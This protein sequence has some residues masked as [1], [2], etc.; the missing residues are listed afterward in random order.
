ML[1][2]VIHKK[3]PGLLQTMYSTFFSKIR[4]LS[5][6]HVLTVLIL[7]GLL[8]GWVLT[9]PEQPKTPD[10]PVLLAKEKPSAQ[11]KAEPK[12]I[13]FAQNKPRVRPDL[14]LREFGQ[15]SPTK[16]FRRAALAELQRTILGV[17]AEFDPL[18]GAPSRVQATGKMLT[19]PAPGKSA[20]QV[21]EQFVERH[22]ALFGHSGTSLTQARVAR[23]DVTE[24]NGMSTLVWQQQFDD[25]PLY[26]TILKA[27]VTKH[28]ELVTVSDSFLGN[29][30]QAARKTEAQRKELIRKPPV[31]AEKA[32]AK[33]AA[34]WDQQVAAVQSASEAS[35]TERR[36]AFSA[37]GLSD[38]KAHLTWMPMSSD[39]LVLAWDVTTFSLP[40]NHMY[41]VVV[42][43]ESGKVLHRTSL[44]VDISDA[45]YQVYA[46][47]GTFQPHDSPTPM[48]PGLTTPSGTQP[49]VVARQTLTLPALNTTASPAGWIN[50]G[51]METLGNNVDAHTDTDDNNAPDLPRPNGGAGR[52]FSFPMDL[53]LAPSTYKDASVTQLFYLNNYIHDR[54]YELGFTESSGNFQTNNFGRGGLGN[55]AVQ[56]DAQDGGGT[57]NANFSTPPDGSPGRMQMYLFSGPNPDRDGDFDAE[58]VVHEYVHGL[59]NR[60]VG[61]GVGIDALQS[62]GM[63]EGWSDF[64]AL[65]LLSEPG[66]D[67]NANYAAGGYATYQLGGLLNNYYFGIRRYPYSTNL[68]KNPLTLRD[69][70]PSQASA[71]AGIPYNPIF[72]VPNAMPDRVHNQGEVWCVTLWEAR[73]NLIAKHGHALGNERMLQLVTDGMK[74]APANPTFL[75]ARD[76]VIQADL[77]NNGGADSN[78]LWA[79]FAKR[80]MGANA[81]VPD[82]GTTIGVVESF[83]MPD[84][85]KVSPTASLAAEGQVGGPMTPETQEYTLLNS[86]TANLNWS[87]TASPAWVSLSLA[88]G[89]LAPGATVQLTATINS[90]A[91]NLPPGDHV[92]TVAFTNVISTVVIQRSITLHVDPIL[93]PIFTED[94]E[95]GT[96]GSAWTLT[97]TGSWRTLNTLAGGP[98]AGARHLTMDSSVNDN[99]SR[100]EATLT[101]D[102]AGRENVRLSFYAK[103]YNE[104]PDGPAPLPFPS[105]GAD[106][107]GV[108]IS[109]DGGAN[110]NFTR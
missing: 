83:E 26:K 24:H 76:A 6:G 85:L 86:G 77:V 45:T 99:Y 70:D 110:S 10:K 104:E 72:G 28:G 30:Q 44:T 94:F 98:R 63:G 100:N 55:D 31:D 95:S 101:L 88:A 34:S 97:G 39:R 43:A 82:A 41:R 102:L 33:A 54:L 11:A 81:Q 84:D 17:Q 103:G 18:S 68:L 78:E 71:H 75:Q 56:A 59:S 74:L 16:A 32:V 29:P 38:T 23:E 40:E 35:G 87:A 79:A 108:A 105:S 58:I 8:L 92:A 67:P 7:G 15:D 12:M 60:L 36:Q 14:D 107:D 46:K 2:R 50:D 27:N 48:A 80:G 65:C 90:Q 93:V 91:N 19:E 22:Q 109:D 9:V 62:A 5:S 66:D 37:Q 52:N 96:L 69:I 61:G 57:D 51:G 73:A 13:K 4:R 64:Y 20:R 42:D 53:G 3:L 21:V 1:S 47:S 25:I 106:F 49:A 89:N